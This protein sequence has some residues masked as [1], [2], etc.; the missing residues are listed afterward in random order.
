MSPVVTPDIVK[1]LAPSGTLRAT[2]N[3]GNMVLAQGTPDAPR[4][5]T[6]DIARELAKRLGVPVE[7]NCFDQAGKAFEGFRSQNLD[8]AFLAIEPVRAAEIEFTPPYV[9]IEGVYMV[10]ENS[11][12]EESRGRRRQR[13]ADRGCERCRV[14]SVPDALTQERDAGARS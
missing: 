9:T 6:V 10:P 11:A 5:I 14:R 2:I 4:G 7:F 3:L 8:I 12:A 1:S 13:R